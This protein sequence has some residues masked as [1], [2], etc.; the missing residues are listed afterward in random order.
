[1]R[2][3]EQVYDRD[4]TKAIS[5]EEI[6]EYV[7]NPKWKVEGSRGF[8]TIIQFSITPLNTQ[9]VWDAKRA[10]AFF[11]W[12][13]FPSR[14]IFPHCNAFLARGNP[15]PLYELMENR[16][17]KALGIIVLATAHWH[18]M[19]RPHSH[20]TLHWRG[21]ETWQFYSNSIVCLIDR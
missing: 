13:G 16:S 5:S 19:V 3:T 8:K 7:S 20:E 11:R 6:F 21:T 14:R 4:T 1:M 12:S 10:S 15:N 17:G 2:K 9:V 18:E